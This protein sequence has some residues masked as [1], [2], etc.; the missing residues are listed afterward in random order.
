[1]NKHELKQNLNFHHSRF[2]EY[3]GSLPSERL[4]LPLESKW[5]PLQQLDH[6]IK[7][8]SPVTMAFSQPAFLL[9]I[10]FGAANRPSR[11]YEVLIEKYQSK[12]AAGGKAPPRFVPAPVSSSLNELSGRLTKKV[13][14]LSE[15]IDSFSEEQ[16]DKLILPHPLLGKL[17]L[18]EMLYFSIYHVQHH[19]K[20]VTIFITQH[21]N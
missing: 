8:I 5:S 11:S 10:I 16:L 3:L 6:I 4:N 17:T 18:R 19:H 14:L 21:P 15:K 20:Q 2:T 7:S 9:R 13:N 1:M 12:L